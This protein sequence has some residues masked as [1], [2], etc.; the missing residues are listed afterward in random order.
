VTNATS[1]GQLRTE[2][3]RRCEPGSQR[4]VNAALIQLRML[5][6]NPVEHQTAR[7]L[8]QASFFTG[9]RDG[10]LQALQ[11]RT[12]RRSGACGP[13][14]ASRRLH[15]T[16]MQSLVPPTVNAGPTSEIAADERLLLP[17]A[18]TLQLSLTSPCGR[19]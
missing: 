9:S 14:R 11:A 4:R 7:A 2:N 8:E 16:C 19:E 3:S 18:P 15:K 12:E 13:A 5:V 6:S 10:E 17:G 1:T